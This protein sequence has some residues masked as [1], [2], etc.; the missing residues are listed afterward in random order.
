MVTDVGLAHTLS[1][2]SRQFSDLPNVN[3]SVPA[4]SRTRFDRGVWEQ[5]GTSNIQTRKHV[6]TRLQ[7][8]DSL[9]VLL[10]TITERCLIMYRAMTPKFC[11]NMLRKTI[12]VCC[13]DA[14]NPKRDKPKSALAYYSIDTHSV[15]N[16]TYDCC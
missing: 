7:R 14:S 2:A 16:P 12:I 9:F 6:R 8:G 15:P 11:F 10:F 13:Q 5:L 3:G 4:L 1:Q